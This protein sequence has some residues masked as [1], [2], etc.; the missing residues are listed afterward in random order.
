MNKIAA[1]QMCSTNNLEENLSTAATLIAQAAAQGVKLAVLP[2]MFVLLGCDSAEKVKIKETAGSGRIQNFLSRLAIKHDIWIVAGTIPIT[3]QHPNK[4]R[5][6]CLVFDN[7]GHQVARYDKRHLFDVT[8][9]ATEVYRESDTTEAGDDVV[10]IDT[11]VGKLGLAVCYDLRFP[12]HFEKLSAQGAEVIAI[13]AAFTVKTGEAH[14]AL[15]ARSRAIDT[16]CYVIGACQG[17]T[18]SNGRQT[19]GH[20]M[21]VSP[22]GSVM[23]EAVNLIPSITYAEIDLEKLYDIRSQIP[24]IAP[25][26]SA[27]DTKAFG[28]M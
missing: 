3:C 11:P 1:I 6:A 19:Y 14:W 27:Q 18:H 5:A 16:F 26:P 8:L 15:L 24:V 9:S 7:H 23:D 17:G 28:L 4:V 22:W 21:I 2:E 12:E 20:T 13:P 10:V 25:V